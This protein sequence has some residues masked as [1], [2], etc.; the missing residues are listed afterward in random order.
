MQIVRDTRIGTRLLIGFGGM[1]VMTVI[2]AVF[3]INRVNEI[4]HSLDVINEVNSVK[5]R[6]A[7]NFRGSV[8]DRAIALRDVT[9][10]SGAGDVDAV[11]ATIDKL[12]G[13][14]QRSAELMDRMFAERSDI[15][16]EERT[17]LGQIKQTE[18][19]TMPLVKTVIDR[20]RA[21]D[22]EGARALLMAEARPAFVEWL[23]RINHF[24]D[25]QENANQVIAER[26]RAVA[27]GFAERM[28]G[29][30]AL[31]LV[32]GVALAWW[33]IGSIRPLKRLT[34]SMLRLAEGDL[35]V[36]LPVAR[37]RD[38]VGE[39]IGAVAVFKRNAQE[40]AELRAEQAAMTERSEHQKREALGA[41]AATV[42]RETTQVVDEVARRTS[43]LNAS[44]EDMATSAQTVSA[45]SDSVSTSARKAL[46]NAETV[47]GAA[48]EMTASIREILR[49]MDNTTA[50]TAQAARTGQT[51]ETT[52][53]SL[54]TAVERIGEVATL[55]G[56]IAGQ[57]NLLALNATIES[58][59]A[60]DAGKG[61]AVVAQEVK[62]LAN[63]TGRSTEEITRQIGEV[64]SATRAAAEAVKAMI[65]NIREI[66]Q[67]S[68]S[69]AGAVRE[70]D[71]ATAEIARGVAETAAASSEVT[72]RIDEVA[73][74]A[75]ANGLR[76]QAVKE[77]GRDVDHSI[78]ALRQTLVRV[79]REAALA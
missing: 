41:M 34:A 6:Y 44:A 7:I 13:D 16:A 9:L 55:I 70:Q 63:Q 14:Y 40:A 39:I 30:C 1:L 76:A 10:V 77:I 69:V 37:G 2:L 75:D 60:G 11:V 47:A 52:V 19:R 56:T 50:L 35:G 65:A 15:G 27:R 54:Q 8:H 53:V 5:Q 21:G 43:R 59:R 64:Q 49:Q 29:L 79:V 58:A 31:V 73:R 66:D 28:I 45:S 17:I 12:A 22:L 3:G 72:V 25:L 51:A 18:S 71:Q 61:F 36:D 32:V 26:T 67:V 78:E 74:E 4:S 62:N 68:A 23:E 20:R 38:E 46:S 24:I 42:E 33:T 48:E 57:T